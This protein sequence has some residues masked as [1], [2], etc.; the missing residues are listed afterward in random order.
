MKLNIFSEVQFLQ[1]LKSLFSQLNVPINYVTDEP[2]T[3]DNILKDTYKDNDT[4]NLIDDVYFV[5]MVDDAS[6]QGNDSI[7]TKD[8]KS[9]YDGILIFGITL[10]QRENNLLPTRTQL[11]EITRAFNRE[12]YYTPVTLVFKYQNSNNEYIA[13][14]N[15]E[16]LKYKQEW[17]EGEKAGKVALLRDINIAKPH[18]GHTDIIKELKI[19][20]S[21]LKAVDSFDKLYKYWQEV[22]N[23][24]I[25]NKKFYNELQSW[26]FWAI[27]EVTFPNA[28]N[29]F[30]FESDDKFD[31]A[32]KEHKGKNVIRLLT[33]LLFIWFIKE[34]NLVPEEI[35][36]EK[37][38]ANNL[39]KDF[40]PQKPHGMFA[41]GKHTSM[42]YRAILQNL[43][44]ATLNQEM[45]KREFRK[46]KVHM[47]VTNLMRYKTYFKNGGDKV[48]LEL[49]NSVPFMN[50]GLFEC[51]DKPHPEIKGKRGGD[52]IIYEDGF[53]DR[54]DNI[55]EVPD[56]LFFDVDEEVDISE[57]IGSKNKI[58]KQAKTRGLLEI[59]KSYKFTITENTPIEEDVALDPEL[60]G[61]VF[62]NLLASYNPETKTTARKQT[63]SFYTPRE[64]VNHMV[65]EC[66]IAYLKNTIKD[67]NGIDE[68]ELDKDL[69][70]LVAFDNPQNP[71]KDDLELQNH[72]IKALDNCKILDP[73][74]GS[75]AFPMGILQKMVHILHK[76]D[77]N[78]TEWKHRQLLR[79]DSAI[80][81]LEEL[82]DVEF[83]QKSINELFKQKEDIEQAF[84]SNEL[85]YGRKLY[86]IENCVYG[87][88]IQSIATQISKLRFFISLVV[89]QKIDNTKPNFGVRPLPNLETKFVAANTLIGI[90]KPAQQGNLFDNSEVKHLENKLKKIRHKLFS[91]KSPARKRELRDE[92]KSLRTQIADVL[93]NNGWHNKTAR[94]LASWDP[95]DQ[96]ASSPFFD[97][98]WMFDITNGF[99]IIIGNPPY[100]ILT[101]NNT[102]NNEL[103]TYIKEYQSIK[104][105]YSKN[106]YTLF[107]E[108]S[109]ELLKNN[110]L[111]SFIVP[112]GLYQTRS[113]TGCVEVMTEFGSTTKI[114]TFS[115]F[116]FE[117]AITGNLI[118][119]YQKQLGLETE[120]YHFDKDYSL[121]KVNEV[122]HKEIAEIE[123]EGILLKSIATAFKGMVVKD[124]SEVLFETKDNRKNKFLLGKNISK[125]K[126]NSSFYTDYENLTIVGG[127]KRLTKHNQYPRILVR[128]TGDT[129]CGAYLTE[130]ALTESTL[131]S[132]WSNDEKFSNLYLIGLLNSKVL[133]HYN[134]KLNI[135][136]QQGFPQILMTDL[137]LL[138]IKDTEQ[139]NKRVVEE[140]VQMILTRYDKT[141][142]SI[143]D[144]IVYNIYFPRHMEELQ[145]DII[146][147]IRNDLATVLHQNKF[148][149]ME[150]KNKVR[151]INQLI[152]IWNHPDNEVRNRIQL[153][154]VRS[155][156]ILKPI[157]ES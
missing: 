88:D 20:T 95:Y 36:E 89:D 142:E 85:D 18:R 60:L 52:I 76:V 71:F 102:N 68:K 80:Q 47:N 149:N 118:F 146:D 129:I 23:V 77:S 128:R 26:Y 25:L 28:P 54:D 30:D 94:Q 48:F 21:G 154:A 13:F 11:A 39:I 148:K 141:I 56:F 120:K 2:T 105:S 41:T 96:N 75:G 82:D 152:Q 127:T 123:K 6:F 64:I 132:I 34:K 126:I 147:H 14:A 9:D 1:A 122:E 157:I 70:T 143:L 45:G 35:F 66:L 130:P 107:I 139:N 3:A 33:R 115:D 137:Q 38:V 144:A 138:P 104:T 100:K 7:E 99:D 133:N 103:N 92:D 16:R 116:V 29:R 19:Q 22:F 43:F 113:Y 98:E 57:D 61:K 151:A 112:E 101:R 59:L 78:N 93:E 155:P 140:L 74:C 51:L 131:Y 86:L 31:E 119:L 46:P 10:H 125:W 110:S 65:D 114:A 50:G 8:I 111:L 81:N 4:F 108:N 135:T 44:F 156:E 55:I 109:I 5:G 121:T 24:S 136:N 106:L 87:V 12:F 91:S 83:R 62:E 117:N 150:E 97:S 73:A 90:E 37:Y 17:R 53:S 134:K 32:V 15:A 153:F 69:H 124:R 58:Y 63:G 67:W 40:T 42:Y 72:I 27:K 79:V 49:M 84:Q 145:I